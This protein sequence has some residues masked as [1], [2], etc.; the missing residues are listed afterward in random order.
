MFD[1]F[2]IPPINW[3]KLTTLEYWLE[4]IANTSEAPYIEYDTYF[5][6]FYLY[7]F[8]V[9]IITGIV[10]KVALVFVDNAHPIQKRSPFFSSSLI[11]LGLFGIF[12]FVMRQINIGIFGA[13]LWLFPMLLYVI[14]MVYYGIR[15]YR[16]RY[17]I[18]I[19]YYKRTRMK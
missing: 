17:S 2:K 6:W 13:R 12:W 5:Y 19:Q 11:W 4:G 10:W 9:L 8:A 18:E 14:F 7:V 1:P 15:Y 16:T 3:S